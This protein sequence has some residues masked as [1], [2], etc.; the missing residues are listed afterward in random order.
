MVNGIEVV[1][2]VD[3]G[4]A[5]T[6]LRSSVVPNPELTQG[7]ILLQCMRGDVKSCPHIQVAV[8]VSEHTKFL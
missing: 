3:S 4:C 2:L 7:M 8:T 6:L 5:Q 1:G